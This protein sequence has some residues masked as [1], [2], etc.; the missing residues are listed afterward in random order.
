[1]SINLQLLHSLPCD[2]QKIICDKSINNF[3]EDKMQ[4][5]KNNH[6]KQMK[7]TF[8]CFP[9]KHFKRWLS[10]YY[11]YKE[12]TLPHSIALQYYNHELSRTFYIMW[13]WNA[14]YGF[15]FNKIETFKFN[16]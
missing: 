11:E 1:M 10:D 5:Y 6:K 14:D 2:L 4:V 16:N 7:M 9:E 12:K 13:N 3:I 15:T 8:S